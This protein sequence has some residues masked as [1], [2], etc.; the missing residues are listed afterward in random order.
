MIIIKSSLFSSQVKVSLIVTTKNH[1]K[2]IDE[3]LASLETFPDGTPIILN[4]VNSSDGTGLALT[5]FAMKKENVIINTFK[6]DLTQ[7]E[8][9]KFSLKTVFTPFVICISGDDAFN[10]DY[11]NFILSYKM[12]AK[13]AVFGAILICDENMKHI[14]VKSSKWNHSQSK[15]RLKLLISN[16]ANS[17]GAILPTEQVRKILN[18]SDLPKTLIEDYWLWWKLVDKVQFIATDTIFVNYRRH[19]KALSYQSKNSSY[20]SSLGFSTGIAYNQARG[21]LE[22]FASIILIIRWGRHAHLCKIRDFIVGFR[23]ARDCDF[24]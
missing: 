2:F 17:Q 5:S 4:D 16:P 6:E 15:N 14:R 20:V 13:S 7:L 21:I 3:C 12:N 10:R 24:V 19:P 22:K 11:K 18:L 23:R 1:E 8:I 9:L